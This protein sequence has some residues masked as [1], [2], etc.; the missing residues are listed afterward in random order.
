MKTL[1]FLT[2]L[3]IS[4]TLTAQIK[5]PEHAIE[6]I[7][8][9]STH[10]T[11]DNKGASFAVVYEK[12]FRKKLS[13]TIELGST[14]HDGSFPLFYTDPSGHILDGSYR[15]TTAGFQIAGHAGYS[16]I[17]SSRHEFQLRAGGLVRL[18]SS[19]YFDELGVLYPIATGLSIPVTY[20]V[21]TTPQR[22][23]AAGASCQLQYNYTFRNRLQL[24]T[25][26]GFQMD[27]NG[28]NIS[29]L[30]VMVGRRF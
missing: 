7:A 9:R 21:N 27:T 1:L 4:K 26:A 30:S 25:L 18:Q 23:Y 6:I 5:L 17:R 16:F 2:L 12:Y 20:F 28:D 22:T 8:G 14:I 13:W 15:Y 10:S 19:S 3:F 29:H 24:G 11:G